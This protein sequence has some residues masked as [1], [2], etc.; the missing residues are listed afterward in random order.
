MPSIS[1]DLTVLLK[2][3]LSVQHALVLDLLDKQDLESY[4]K[5]IFEIDYIPPTVFQTLHRKGF[6]EH[7]GKDF[8]YEFESSRLTPKGVHLLREIRG[9][10]AVE[11]MLLS[12]HK[13]PTDT[14]EWA[15]EWRELWPKGVKSGGY[16]VRSHI[17]D[18]STK[19]SRFQK[20]YKYPKETIFKATEQYLQEKQ[21]QGYGFI[22]TAAYFIEKS[23]I[24][25]LAELCEALE[26]GDSHDLSSD[27]RSV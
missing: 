8:Q 17:K 12:K 11:E 26:S 23:G 19:L 14:V 4:E 21:L 10:A 24:S 25:T 1:I 15:E 3:K 2:E 13:R 5:Y 9:L 27:Y 20:K 18:I 22:K 7:L 6:I 16:L